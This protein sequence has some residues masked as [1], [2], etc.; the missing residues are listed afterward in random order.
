[1]TSVNLGIYEGRAQTLLKK[2]KDA[3]WE[4]ITKTAETYREY[5]S[6]FYTNQ[7]TRAMMINLPMALHKQGSK[8][9]SD[10]SDEKIESFRQNSD[11]ALKKRNETEEEK[12]ETETY[13]DYEKLKE[14]VRKNAK[15]VEARLIYA[16][17]FTQPPVRDDYAQMHVVDKIKDASDPNINYY[18][19]SKGQ[20]ILNHYKTKATYGQA[21]L[22]AS[23]E[24]RAAI[25]A[26]TQQMDS[27]VLFKQT[28][29]L[30]KRFKSHTG[31]YTINDVRHSFISDFL[32]KNPTPTEKKAI[33]ER[34]LHSTNLQAKYERFVKQED[35]D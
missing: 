32:K 35:S 23:P 19:K 30:T 10:W 12:Q 34:M 14:D 33:A 18:V 7:S 17:Y 27:N 26:Y 8:L 6:R 21:I 11:A 9:V 20:F 13:V 29:T 2:D 3:T 16:L 4:S 5:V 22:S 1:M 28:K 31:G 15:S 24:A 25:R